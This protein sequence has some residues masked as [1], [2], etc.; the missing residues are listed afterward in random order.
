MQ[1][2]SWDTHNNKALA[3]FLKPV[4]AD[5]LPLRDWR[6]DL[7]RRLRAKFDAATDN[8]TAIRRMTCDHDARAAAHDAAS[9]SDG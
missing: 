6:Y 3:A 2:G 7:H 8:A 9:D 1:R 4:S 5:P